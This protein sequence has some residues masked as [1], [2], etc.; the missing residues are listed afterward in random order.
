ML[1]LKLA[2]STA[3]TPK[4]GLI[5]LGAIA[6]APNLLVANLSFNKLESVSGLLGLSRLHTLNVSHNQVT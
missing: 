2:N 4:Q 3:C 1:L 6:E 5:D